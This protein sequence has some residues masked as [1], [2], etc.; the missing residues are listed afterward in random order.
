MSDETKKPELVN[1]E[2]EPQL[3]DKALKEI[4]GGAKASP[5]LY[6]ASCKGTHIPK[7]II[8]LS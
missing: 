8:E 1:A 6:E 2:E 3:D 5:K 4:V 7:V